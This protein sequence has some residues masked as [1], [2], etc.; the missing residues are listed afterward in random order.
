MSYVPQEKYRLQYFTGV[1]ASIWIGDIWAEEV[2]GVSFA[3]TQNLI[4]LFGYASSTFDAVAKGKIMVQ[5]TFEINFIDEGYLYF[6]LHKM[7]SQRPDLSVSTQMS[8]AILNGEIPAQSPV[9]ERI[10]D[11]SSTALGLAL[12]ENRADAVAE[13]MDFLASTDVAGM[14]RLSRELD[15]QRKAQSFVGSPESKNSIIYDMIP[16]DLMG[17]FGNP[18]LT[19]DGMTQKTIK[20][21]FLMSNE[22]IV[23][24]DDMPIKE[25]YSFIG[26]IHQ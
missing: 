23:A 12:T 4:P 2:F 15:V 5:G 20:N 9:A 3:A 17:L 24:M 18:E 26:Q 6:I 16:F 22:M 11:L 14:R 25:R 10:K 7:N 8:S 19:K 1:Q 13:I 21:C